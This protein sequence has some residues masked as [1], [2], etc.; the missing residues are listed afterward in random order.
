ML[1]HGP[2]GWGEFAPFLEYDDAEAARWLAAAL[3]ACTTPWPEPVRP[4][5]PVNATV[6]AVAAAVVPSVLAR[7]PGC[8]TAKVKV[9]EAGQ[10][11]ADDEARVAAVR[12]A[13][14]PAGR[15][16]VDANGGWSLEQ[17]RRALDVLGPYGLEYA[18]QPCAALEDLAALRGRGVLVAADESVRKAE[19]PLRVARLGA[20]DV[21][22]LKVAP[23]GGVAAGARVARACGLPVVVSSA[24]DTSVGISAGVALAA[25]LPELPY[26]C[27][28][29]TTS[30]M[31]LG[32]GARAAVRRRRVDA[33]RAGGAGRGAA[34]GA[35]R[36]RRTAPPGGGRG[37]SAAPRCSEGFPAGRG[38]SRVSGMSTAAGVLARLA[39]RRDVPRVVEVLA[40]AFADD[41][42]LA[43]LFPDGEPRRRRAFFRLDVPRSQRL[44]GAWTTSDGAGAAV[45]YPPGAWEPSTW[46][47]LRVLPTAARAFGRRLGLAARVLAALHE[48]HPRQPHW[49][50][51]S[52]GAV[53]GRQGQGLG[54]A[55]LRPVLERC[56]R[57]GLPAYLEATSPRNQALY[58]R[59]GFV[60]RPP[61]PLPGGATA[62]PMWR[63]P[64]RRTP[65]TIGGVNPSTALARVLVDELVRGGVREAVLSP[66]SRSAPLAFAL[67]RADADG[68]LRLHVRID[69]RSAA[70]L[71]LGLAKASGRPVPVVTTSGTATANLHP[72]VLEA[73]H[74]GVPLL[75]LTADRP[76]ELRGTGANQTVD[77]VGLYGG[78]VRAAFD[79]GVPESRPGSVAYWRSLV[80]RA[81]AAGRLAGAGAA[82]RRAARA[83]GAGRRRVV[84]GAA[85]RA[86]TGGA[87]WT[88]RVA[89]AAAAVADDLPARTLVV[90]GDAAPAVTAAAVA[91]AAARGLAGVAEPSASAGA[92]ALPAGELVLSAPGF[93]DAHRPER[94]LV[95][96]RPT[97]SRVVARLVAGSPV[98][99]VGAAGQWSDPARQAAR[100]LPGVPVAGGPVDP[101]WLPAW[102]AAARGRGRRGRRRAG[103]RARAARAGGR[104]GGAGRR[105]G[106]ARRRVVEAGAR[107]V[108]GGRAGG[109][110]RPGQPRGG[111]D[112]RDRLHRARGRARA[113]RRG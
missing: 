58:R 28:L 49:Y 2:A 78:A 22:V 79:L 94:V 34:G 16:R 8:T 25:A 19:D 107:P 24:L 66:G 102:Q 26:A 13:L 53:P 109:G 65:D 60:D 73:S 112:R 80:C 95:V 48:H 5:V 74:A 101:A 111:R 56:D 30:L 71:A 35:G 44:G 61:L 43:P 59:H 15:V 14:G 87:P 77:Q 89:G 104:A 50:L 39:D 27:G 81:L 76:P 72:A 54:S 51:Y 6:P 105:A 69:E 45:W 4:S 98:D 64:D 57:E 113:R 106:A 84:A 67:H 100:V 41:P 12:A 55:L 97:L 103:R 42:L 37:C 21:L 68:R 91:L 1:L 40:E 82:Q 75:L 88:A 23:L 9:A 46:E 47:D 108:P 18:E 33:G 10:S 11:L 110:H 7:F 62:Y 86:A 38:R 70:F 90:V 85:G 3:E 17:A 52:L 32:R 99:V 31:A 83:A 29:A 20:A 96:G 92:A 93:L 36:V 63:E